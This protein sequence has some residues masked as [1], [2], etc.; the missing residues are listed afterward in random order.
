MDGEPKRIK[1]FIGLWFRLFFF[2]NLGGTDISVNCLS[3]FWLVGS[4][5]NII[6][7]IFGS[8]IYRFSTF[9][10]CLYVKLIK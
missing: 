7:N 1:I 4:F 3:N 5:C 9:I 10:S 8:T 6:I 2:V